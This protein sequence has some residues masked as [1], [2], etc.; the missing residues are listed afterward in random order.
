MRDRIRNA[1]QPKSEAN[2]LIRRLQ[3]ELVE[4][5]FSND[6]YLD[7]SDVQEL[8]VK[9]I[10][11][12]RGIWPPHSD[13]LTKMEYMILDGSMTPKV[14]KEMSGLALNR[15]RFPPTGPKQDKKV[16]YK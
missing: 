6:N 3:G 15:K 8:R 16:G 10:R 13:Y 11:R 12:D 1:K 2:R 5:V 9:L 4:G 14:F 7:L